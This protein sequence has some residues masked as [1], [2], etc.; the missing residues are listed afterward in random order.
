VHDALVRVLGLPSS[1]FSVHTYR[2]EDF[3]VVFATEELRRVVMSRPSVVHRGAA[4]FFKKWTRQSQASLDVW[5]SK[6]ELVI[7]GV[8]PHAFDKEVIQELLGTSCCLDVIAPET[9]SRADLATFKASAWTEDV[10]LI[11]SART[12]ATPEPE[13]PA[14]ETPSSSLLMSED[15]GSTLP[16]REPPDLKLLRYKVLIHVD[17]VMTAPAHVRRQQPQ[18]GIH[19]EPSGSGDSGNGGGGQTRTVTRPPWQLG[20]PD[21]RGGEGCRTS[22][23][24]PRSYCQVAASSPASWRL[25]RM[26]GRIRPPEMVHG[27]QSHARARADREAFSPGH[28]SISDT[29]QGDSCKAA[30]VATAPLTGPLD[31]LPLEDALADLPR[32]E[33]TAAGGLSGSEDL[34]LSANSMSTEESTPRSH[35]LSIKQRWMPV[36]SADSAE[37]EMERVEE[38]NQQFCAGNLDDAFFE[39]S[40]STVGRNGPILEAGP[41]HEADMVTN[42]E[43]AD[44]GPGADPSLAQTP[45]EPA[46]APQIIRQECALPEAA[47]Q[48][49]E[50]TQP[51]A[52]S[53]QPEAMVTEDM[54]LGRMKQFCARILK[55]LAPPLL[56]EVQSN[57]RLR[58]EA[59]PFTPRRSTRFATLLRTTATKQT[60][61]A[62]AAEAVL[63]K[64]L[65]I[66]PTELAVDETA[67]LEFRQ[68]FDSLIR[69]QHLRVLAA[70]FGKTL[71]ARQE[72]LQA[73]VLECGGCD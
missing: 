42:L 34:V 57:T 54:V 66:S 26:D 51:D 11:P 70:I 61:K 52:T 19:F 33:Q 59:E 64:A 40:I 30:D 46:E 47:I 15:T 36:S 55:T 65:G 12:L 68:F 27:L 69:E 8:P 63:L 28:V 53:P 44:V 1:G 23:V 32:E 10:E 25:P 6:V 3:L 43:L 72:L 7:E 2:P 24:G 31:E 45:S 5:R 71:P 35:G 41:A 29:R 16:A 49:P 73:A 50:G 58:P 37:G 39:V 9:A 60:K 18:E 13:E 14:V 20:V 62:S 21:R 48:P 17:K 38:D 4:L 22:A 67:L 56:K